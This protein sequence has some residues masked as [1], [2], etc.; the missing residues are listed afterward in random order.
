[1]AVTLTSVD[2]WYSDDVNTALREKEQLLWHFQ[3]YLW[4]LTC[5]VD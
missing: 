5:L 4:E 2:Y 3:Q 1:M